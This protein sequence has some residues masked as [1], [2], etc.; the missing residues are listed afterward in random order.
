MTDQKK[1]AFE[2]ALTD[3]V[4][5]RY[6]KTVAEDFEPVELSDS[7]K[8]A[9]EGLT[10]KTERKTWKY[11]NKTWKRILIAAVLMFLLAATAFAAVPALREGLIRFFTHDNGVAYTFEFTQEDLDRAPKEIETYYAPSFVPDRFHL[12]DQ[13]C[14]AITL[15]YIYFDDTGDTYYYSQSV[16]W[17]Y[18]I[19]PD[20]LDE[21][22]KE[23]TVNSENVLVED[24]ILQGYEVKIIHMPIRDLREHE[25]YTVALWTDH[26][27]FFELGGPNL[28][29]EE[30]DRIIA[31]MTVI[32]PP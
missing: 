8:K 16:L 12:A 1:T 13:S 4:L 31:S 19:D 32:S 26:Q 20:N 22:L 15:D 27:Y 6:Q 17:E 7:Y 2:K 5:A 25:E 30:I 21:V 18:D 23:H 28:N 11:V 9:I 10:R 24:A 3:A 29:A 14:T